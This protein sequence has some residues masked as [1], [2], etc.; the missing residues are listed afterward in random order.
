MCLVTQ[1]CLTL[2]D[3]MDCSL[4][5]FSVH[6]ILQ[7]IL[8]WVAISFSRGSSRPR[9]RTQLFC[10]AGR[11]LNLWATRDP[12]SN[13]LHSNSLFLFFSSLNSPVSPSLL[14]IKKTRDWLALWSA[15]LNPQAESLW[16]HM[17]LK[18]TQKAKRSC[19]FL[20]LKMLQKWPK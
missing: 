12:N 19:Y 16:A 8:E 4:P 17:F 5:D 2:C 14:L 9:D 3:P 13:L 6:G 11:R 1:L 10:I 7:A 20:H 15:C 18:A